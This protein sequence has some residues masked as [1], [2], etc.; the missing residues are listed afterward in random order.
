[1]PGLVLRGLFAKLQ[2][3]GSGWSGIDSI[4]SSGVVRGSV[5][6]IMPARM[7]GL[8]MIGGCQSLAGG[9]EI[10]LGS[11]F[12]GDYVGNLERDYAGISGEL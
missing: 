6:R 10:M 7:R 3:P 12:D 2:L 1:M 8:T 5:T 9:I 4:G 11:G